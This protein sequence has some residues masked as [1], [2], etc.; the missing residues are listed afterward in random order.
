MTTT[1]EVRA[2][3]LS[4]PG[5]TE[6]PHFERTALKVVNKRIFAS[7]HEESQTLNIKLSLSEQK[8]FSSYNSK[9]IYPVPN[10]FGL[11]GWTTFEL[12]KLDRDVVTEAL[13]S[14]YNEVFTSKKAKK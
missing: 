6:Q 4:F 8:A 1:A 10:K 7:I 3:A 9:A 13:T 14:A 5:T 12:K 11:Q 2:F